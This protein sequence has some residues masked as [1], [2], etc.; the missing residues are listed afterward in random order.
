[1][2]PNLIWDEL[3]AK[4][5]DNHRVADHRHLEGEAKKVCRLC[6]AINAEHAVAC[7]TCGRK[8]KLSHL[9]PSNLKLGVLKLGKLKPGKR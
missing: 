5:A 6:G 1:M 2:N 9:K 8:L 4:M 7:G 3:Q